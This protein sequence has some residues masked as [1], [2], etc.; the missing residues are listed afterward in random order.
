MAD[1]SLRLGARSLKGLSL[2][3]K[4]HLWPYF[5]NSLQQLQLWLQQISNKV[6]S[7]SFPHSRISQ[8]ARCGFFPA[9]SFRIFTADHYLRNRRRGGERSALCPDSGAS[10][11]P[12][13][14]KH[15][16]F[17]QHEH[18]RLQPETGHHRSEKQLPTG[19]GEPQL[20]KWSVR[21]WKWIPRRV[22]G[23][24]Q[25]GTHLHLLLQ[26]VN[27]RRGVRRPEDVHQVGYRGR[28]WSEVNIQDGTCCFF[29]HLD[30]K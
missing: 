13:R 21:R 27:A 14:K 6:L 18:V 24:G 2:P 10:N 16:N 25:R 23:S 30:T 15:Y 4:H 29:P 5:V 12:I 26:V 9:S 1:T 19:L 22:S 11:N 3:F 8:T 7:L 28:R 17:A 20:S